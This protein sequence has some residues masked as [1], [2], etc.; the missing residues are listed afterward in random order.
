LVLNTAEEAVRFC[1]DV[2]SPHVKILL[3]TFHMNIE[4]DSLPYAIRQAGDLLAYM[5]V[6]EGNRK[7]PGKG[8][9]P[10]G[11]MGTA[12]REIG[13][14]GRIVMEPFVQQGGQVGKDIKVFRDLSDGADEGKLDADLKQSLEFLKGQF[15]G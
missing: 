11:G 15:V 5:H 12:L 9:L 4:E 14:D 8:H 13:F 7:V 6:G 3:D 10:W 1:Q 2:D